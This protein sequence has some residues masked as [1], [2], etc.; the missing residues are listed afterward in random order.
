M[1]RY[2]VI[3]LIV[4]SLCSQT[5]AQGKDTRLEAEISNLMKGFHGEI[6][7]CVYDLK[8]GKM[9]SIHGDSIFPTASIVK[10]PILLGIMRETEIGRLAYHQRLTYT[11]ALYYSEGDD[12][13]SNFKAGSTI[14]LSKVMMLMLTISDNCASLWLQGLAGGGARINQLLDS[15]GYRYTRVNSRTPG[16]E[17]ARELYGWG[18]T[19]PREMCLIMKSIVEGRA[20]SKTSS[21]KMLRLLGRQYW[22]EEALAEIPA[23]IFTADKNGAIDDSRNEILYVN[24]P[25]PYIVSIFTKNIQDKSWESNNEAW[26]L[27]RKVSALLWKYYNSGVAG[28]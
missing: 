7:L 22:D 2:V 13:L 14:E 26:E 27:T 6:G 8:G 4:C 18:Q 9:V 12:I 11:D 20:L 5:R 1:H 16:R 3:G 25:H 24:A 21:D 23:G 19:T 17:G 28:K 10:V 15:L